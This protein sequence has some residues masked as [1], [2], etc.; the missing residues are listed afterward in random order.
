M[1]ERKN[2]K[3]NST[4][5]PAS[6]RPFHQSMQRNYN[7][8]KVRTILKSQLMFLYGDKWEVMANKLK[9]DGVKIK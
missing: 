4:R 3:R 1:S 2:I 6:E 8:P 7:T 9:D 5:V